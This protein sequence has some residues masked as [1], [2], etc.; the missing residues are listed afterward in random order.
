MREQ[1]FAAELA[2]HAHESDKIVRWR[3]RGSSDAALTHTAVAIAVKHSAFIVG[4][5]F[6]EIEKV[7]IL[8]AAALLPDAS[9]AL[10]RIVRCCVDCRPGLPA[11]IGS[12]DERVPY[13]GETHCLIVARDVSA[14]KT[15]SSAA[16]VATGGAATDSFNFG[17]VYDAVRRAKIDVVEPVNGGAIA[18]ADG[19]TS[20]A[21]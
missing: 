13:S 10:N 17:C 4:G 18:L 11:V 7:T 9:H 16:S 3:R 2:C 15:N 21:F 8:G 1:W 14:E 20:V 5:D 19:D 12:S 6:I